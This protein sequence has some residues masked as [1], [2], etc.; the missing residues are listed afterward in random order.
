MAISFLSW[1]WPCHFLAYVTSDVS[2]MSTHPVDPGSYVFGNLKI[3]F[4]FLSFLNT[5]IAPLPK[6]KLTKISDGIWSHL[7]TMSSFAMAKWLHVAS[8]IIVI[9]SFWC[10]H[11]CNEILVNMV[12]EMVWKYMYI[13]I[14]HNNSICSNVINIILPNS[15]L[16]SFMILNVTVCFWLSTII[17]GIL[18]NIMHTYFQCIPKPS[19]LP[20][21]QLLFP[22]WLD[23]IGHWDQIAFGS[24]VSSQLNLRLIYHW[25]HFTSP[26]SRSFGIWFHC[27]LVLKHLLT[28]TV[29]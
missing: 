10:C 9:K 23:K 21:W 20:R 15:C 24:I 28:P 12:N 26:H 6:T 14:G 8:G 27:S 3:N 4:H 29:Y 1:P 5:E 25:F 16:V 18:Y 13:K 11:M 19:H 7:T 17:I 2:T 22:H